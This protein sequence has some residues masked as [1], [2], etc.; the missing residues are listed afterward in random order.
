MIQMNLW[1][2]N[3]LTDV[4]NRLV[5]TKWGSWGKVGI[6]RYKLLYIESIS[7]KALQYW[8]GN[9]IQYRMVSHNGVENKKECMDLVKKD[10]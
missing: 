4:E 7:Q 10:W 9:Y 5:V 1:K 6:S 3:R 8:T 2:R